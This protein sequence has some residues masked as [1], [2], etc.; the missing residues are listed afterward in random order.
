MHT[1]SE[2]KTDVAKLLVNAK[3]DLA[4]EKIRSEYKEVFDRDDELNQGKRSKDIENEDGLLIRR[5]T[6]TV[7]DIIETL[8]GE[9]Y[10][11]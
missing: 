8:Y 10:D 4:I 6:E 11:E 1:D 5:I 2:I 9:K 7:R 3:I